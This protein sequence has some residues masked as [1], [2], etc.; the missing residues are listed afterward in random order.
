M[1]CRFQLGCYDLMN[2]E[3]LVTLSQSELLWE[4]FVYFKSQ[5]LTT[6]TLSHNRCLCIYA[7]DRYTYY[8]KIHIFALLVLDKSAATI[9]N[10]GDGNDKQGFVC[11]NSQLPCSPQQDSSSPAKWSYLFKKKG[12]EVLNCQIIF[13]LIRRWR[14]LFKRM[15]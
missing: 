1:S 10:K 6:G 4:L 9:I 14:Q 3:E 12:V 11:P 13:L 15:L 7:H 2:F 5:K 8:V